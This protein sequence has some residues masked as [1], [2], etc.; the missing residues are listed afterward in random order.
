MS[1]G[2]EQEVKLVVESVEAARR[3]VTTAGGRLVVSRRL[4]R[5]ALFDTPDHQLRQRG[6]GFRIRRDAARTIFTFKG[7]VLRDVVKSREEIETIVADAERGE[8][9]VAGLGFRRWFS[10]EKY[11][12]E[13]ELAATSVAI[14]DT[15]IGVFIE[16]EG[17]PDAIAAAARLLGRGPADYR[18]E[19]YA[20]LYADW[21]KSKGL[22]PGDMR[23]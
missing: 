9:I 18:L 14:D 20:Q 21:C 16:I 15:P 17:A 5:D 8:A 6:C 19:S 13:Y 12:E 23:F 4:L 3:A 1:A 10:A 2:L 7:P 11:R 22:V